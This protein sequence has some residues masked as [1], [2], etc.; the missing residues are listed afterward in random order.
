LKQQTQ[1]K[2]QRQQQKQHI[3]DVLDRFHGGYF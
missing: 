3:D 1:H 2:G